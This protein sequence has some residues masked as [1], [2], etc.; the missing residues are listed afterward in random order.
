[1]HAFRK[2]AYSAHFPFNTCP[3]HLNLQAKRFASSFRVLVLIGVAAVFCAA[4]L[5]RMAKSS[6]ASKAE[7][8]RPVACSSQWLPVLLAA[9]TPVPPTNS[10]RLVADNHVFTTKA[11]LETAAEE[12]N[13][14]PSAAEVTYGT[15]ETWDVSGIT[16]MSKLFHELKD[17][18][19]DIS[20]WNTSG[21]TNMDRMF[22][23]RA[24]AQPLAEPF[25]ACSSRR[26]RLPPSRLPS[27]TSHVPAPRF[28]LTSLRFGRERSSS[29][30]C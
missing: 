9:N 18:D 11:A 13:A 20:S 2:T 1:M 29:T 26:P 28:V 19:A 21:V 15:I 24:L 8:N 10:R 5:P 14:N 4:F 3:S 6:V 12:Y 25:P 27:H 30:S 16:D 22:D 23:V 7:A 17:F